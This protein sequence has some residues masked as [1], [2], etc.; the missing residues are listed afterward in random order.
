MKVVSSDIVR[1]PLEVRPLLI[2]RT[3]VRM[4]VKLEKFDPTFISSCCRDVLNMVA[5]LPAN[6]RL[7][8]VCEDQPTLEA[9]QKPLASTRVSLE[10]LTK[11]TP[12]CSAWKVYYDT[13]RVPPEVEGL[14]GLDIIY[15]KVTM[16]PRR[17]IR[18]IPD[19]A[20]YPSLY[21]QSDNRI[22][23]PGLSPNINKVPPRVSYNNFPWSWIGVL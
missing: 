9:L 18:L 11:D 4:G 3:D 22:V 13:E 12:A 23:P 2:V 1:R 10:V 6:Q 8:V 21:R 15:R 5:T 19:D 20:R 7:V 16:P 17:K 14:V